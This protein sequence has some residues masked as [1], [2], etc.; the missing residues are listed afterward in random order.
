MIIDFKLDE[1]S[2]PA[3][4]LMRIKTLRNVS[5]DGRWHKLKIAENFEVTLE[6]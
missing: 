3:Q 5:F 1:T 6:K 4:N 2:D